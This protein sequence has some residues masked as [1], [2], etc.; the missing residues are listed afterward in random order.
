LECQAEAG[1]QGARWHPC[2][3]HPRR[4]ASVPAWATRLAGRCTCPSW[5]S[6]R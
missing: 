5:T 2:R 4:I 1:G 3:H 6:S